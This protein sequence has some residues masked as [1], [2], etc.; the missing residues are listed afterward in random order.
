MCV[1]AKWCQ[2]IEG[3][4]QKIPNVH[5]SPTASLPLFWAASLSDYNKKNIPASSCREHWL[6][7]QCQSYQVPD[8]QCWQHVWNT[9]L[10]DHWLPCTCPLL[11]QPKKKVL[12]ISAYDF[13]SLVSIQNQE[14]RLENVKTSFILW[15]QRARLSRTDKN[16]SIKPWYVS[17]LSV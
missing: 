7:V 3:F 11:S 16:L 4:Q 8:L 9:L 5:S 14:Y 15:Y 12:Q 10:V 13:S 17:Y 1:D 6:L 2:N